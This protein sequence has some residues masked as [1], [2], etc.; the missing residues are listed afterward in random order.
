MVGWSREI[1]RLLFLR[2]TLRSSISPS[3]VSPLT[4]LRKRST[5]K[6]SAP[7]WQLKVFFLL[8]LDETELESM[9]Q[10]S[11]AHRLPHSSMLCKLGLQDFDLPTA[12]PA[13][14]ILGLCF[15]CFETCRRQF[16]II[17]QRLGNRFL[18]IA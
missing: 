15:P 9:K 16:R 3:Y 18:V 12:T 4:C 2:P 13:A 17:R 8:P 1:I 14:A 10:P 7:F 5:Q 6:S 11:R